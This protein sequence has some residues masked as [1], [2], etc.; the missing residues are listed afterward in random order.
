MR[1]AGLLEK[2]E[3][4]FGLIIEM[5]DRAKLTRKDEKSIG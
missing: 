4:F 3:V 1:A 2:P 5:I